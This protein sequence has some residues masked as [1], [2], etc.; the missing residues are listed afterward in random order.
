MMEIQALASTEKIREELLQSV[1]SLSDDKANTRT[2]EGKWTVAQVLEHLF[3][4]ERAIVQGMGK[5]LQ[6]A[7]NPTDRK[8]FHLSLDRTRSI[9]APSFVEPSPEPQPAD[10]LLHKLEGSRTALRQLLAGIEDPGILTRKSYPHPVF[11]QMDLDQWVEFIGTHEKRHLMQIEEI[12]GEL[13][14]V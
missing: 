1:G 8:P 3:L 13:P 14:A 10:E 11:G 2:A 12:K 7:D 4:M 5:A 9:D 6:S